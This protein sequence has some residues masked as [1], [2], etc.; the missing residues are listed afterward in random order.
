MF[1]FFKLKQEIQQISVL[2]IQSLKAS[3]LGHP[4]L[5]EEWRQISVS[6][7]FLDI[8][9]PIIPTTF[10]QPLSLLEVFME[11]C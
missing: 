10:I 4:S 2:G 11:A 5:G 1:F 3:N 7:Y 9:S 6:D 8:K